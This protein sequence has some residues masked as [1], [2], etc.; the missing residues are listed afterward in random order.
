MT[1]QTS[2]INRI[3]SSSYPCAVESSTSSVAEGAGGADSCV[4]VTVVVIESSIVSGC[5]EV[6]KISPI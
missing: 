1:M 4:L 5:W 2:S 3:C 6:R